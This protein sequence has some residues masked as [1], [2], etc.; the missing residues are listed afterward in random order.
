MFRISLAVQLGAAC[1]VLAASSAYGQQSWLQLRNQFTASDKCLAMAND[2]TQANLEMTT[3]G[4]TSAQRWAV[5]AA[6]VQGGSQLRHGS[7]RCL[8]V[9]NDG[10]NNQLTLA[11]CA[12]VTGQIWEVA[13]SDSVGYSVLRTRFTGPGRCLDVVNDGANNKLAMADCGRFSGQYW[14]MTNVTS[15][16]VPPAASTSVARTGMRAVPPVANSAGLPR[17][18]RM[19]GVKYLHTDCGLDASPQAAMYQRC[20]AH[21]GCEIVARKLSACNQMSALLAGLT[22]RLGTRTDITNFDLFEVVQP[23]PTQHERLIQYIGE[24]RKISYAEPGAPAWKTMSWGKRDAQSHRQVL[25]YFEGRATMLPGDK[26]AKSTGSRMALGRGVAI[27]EFGNMMRG[28]F[29]EGELHGIGHMLTV[30]S[31]DVI[32]MSAGRLRHGV[33][34]GLSIH[35]RS[36]GMVTESMLYAADSTGLNYKESGILRSMYRDDRGVAMSLTR[37]RNDSEHFP[38]LSGRIDPFK[39]APQA[40]NARTPQ[41][42]GGGGKP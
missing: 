12:A 11:P 26:V 37:N 14:S 20:L 36:D 7:G 6:G 32:D 31:R 4:D 13:V 10:A 3:C 40:G 24:A 27:N 38:N 5:V 25:T 8:D 16:G 19:P 21:T 41:L 1:V 29:K 22:E 30:A 23:K 18:D 15:S 39:S 9:I 33:S 35:Q 2:G 17:A 28:D 42:T 34:M